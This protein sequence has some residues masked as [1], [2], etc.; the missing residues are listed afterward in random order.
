[1]LLIRAFLRR[2]NLDL[3]TGYGDGWVV[4]FGDSYSLAGFVAWFPALALIVCDTERCFTST[5]I[6]PALSPA[7]FQALLASL[8]KFVVRAT[9]RPCKLDLVISDGDGW[10]VAFGNSYSLAGLVDGRGGRDGESDPE[11]K[12][13]DEGFHV[14]LVQ[15]VWYEGS[16]RVVVV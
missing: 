16:G 10:I 7:L 11:E 6:R 13:G 5:P 4:A 12:E 9:T 3:V 8:K 2:C 15:S 1:M 14:V